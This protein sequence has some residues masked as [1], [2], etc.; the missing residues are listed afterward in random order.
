ME[1]GTEFCTMLKRR[2]AFTGGPAMKG[3]TWVSEGL[4]SVLEGRKLLGGTLCRR[5]SWEGSVLGR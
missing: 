2:S 3:I 5:M 4:V 1:D